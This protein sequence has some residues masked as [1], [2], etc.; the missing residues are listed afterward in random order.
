MKQKSLSLPLI[1][2][3]ILGQY[4]NAVFASNLKAET[5]Q[6]IL[7]RID[8]IVE[9]AIHLKVFPGCQVLVMKDGKPLYDKSFGH[10]TYDAT[11]KI[12]PTT[13]YDL[14]SLSKTTG[15]LLAVMKLYDNGQLKLTDKASDY[16]AFLRGTNKESITISELLFHESGLP[17]GLPFYEL[18]MQKKNVLSLPKIPQ[19]STNIIPLNSRNY[20][21]KPDWV[22]K[23]P[24]IGFQSQVTDSFFITNSF[25]AAAMQMIANAPLKSKTYL[26]SCLNFILLKEVVETISNT[27][28][29][30]FL[31]KEFYHP[32]GLKSIMYLPLR[33]HTKEE[34][35]PTVQKD[36]LRNRTVQGF[37]HDPDA[38]FFGGVSGN[39][40]LFATAHDVATVYQLLLNN[41]E[42]DGKRYL[43]AETCK[44]FT[45]IT[46]ASGRRGLGFD[47]P[48][49]GNPKENL[50]C[51][52]APAAVYG[53]TGYTGT[54][55][56][57]DPTNQL[58]Y[59]FL[60]NRTYPND[61]VNK[62]AKLHIRPKIQEVIYQAIGKDIS[63][64]MH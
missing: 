42:L 5:N 52:S 12:E 38:A 48:V 23:S 63:T 56:W 58:I 14:A 61:G 6:T 18:A 43:S 59:V 9:N 15:T 24:N 40:G 49:C 29:D 35:A 20:E 57:V 50:C 25:H 28:L 21:Y 54:C 41:G 26:Y 60:S 53:H 55:C 7:N 4:R 10:Y 45:T 2:T 11:Q 37:V 47:K 39:A 36:F 17:A 13:L 34:I 8:S 30:E 19:D 31:D 33:S 62:L 51:E 64:E 46:S 27:K 3:L 16:L 44:L 22:S 32:M 1:I